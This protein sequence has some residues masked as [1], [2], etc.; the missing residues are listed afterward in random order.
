MEPEQQP[1]AQRLA[2]T[3][4]RSLPPRILYLL[5]KHKFGYCSSEE[6]YTLELLGFVDANNSS[7]HGFRT[8]LAT[9]L[10]DALET[11]DASEVPAPS[12]PVPEVPP[13]PTTPHP[14]FDPFSP[15]PPAIPTFESAIMSM[16]RRSVW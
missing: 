2:L 6:E 16:R 5:C 3:I 15:T 14:R 1:L 4:A 11:P 7:K 10:L 9:A 8:A 13:M 12:D